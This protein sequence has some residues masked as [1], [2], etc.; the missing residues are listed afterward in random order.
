VVY[1]VSLDLWSSPSAADTRCGR[2]R[3]APML[4]MLSLL[5]AHPWTSLL[6]AILVVFLAFKL[7]L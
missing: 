6:L 1:V 5:K 7:V 2:K 4:A 3:S